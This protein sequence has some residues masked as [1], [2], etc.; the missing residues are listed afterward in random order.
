M[1]KQN[2]ML[3]SKVA[4]FHAAR[5]NRPSASVIEKR[6]LELIQFQRKQ[7][8]ALGERLHRLNLAL[9]HSAKK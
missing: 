6:A 5:G 8:K 4:S 9:A 7:L 1:A 2:R 3:G